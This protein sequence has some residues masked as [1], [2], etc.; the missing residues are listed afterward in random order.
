M[1]SCT[2]NRSDKEWREGRS[3]VNNQIKPRNVFSF[4]AG[5]ND[6]ATHFTNYLRSAR[7]ENDRIGDIS[8]PIY[9]FCNLINH[10]LHDVETLAI[11]WN[12]LH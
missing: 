3:A 11:G 5:L 2:R 8:I 6:V 4:T 9:L 7:D 1:F 12:Q 10:S